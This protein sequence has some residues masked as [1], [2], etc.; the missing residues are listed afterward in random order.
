MSPAYAALVQIRN[1][2]VNGV[3]TQAQMKSRLL[4][5][6]ATNPAPNSALRGL[7]SIFASGGAAEILRWVFGQV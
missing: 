4:A 6:A 7:L 1:S 2:A 3:K 5:N